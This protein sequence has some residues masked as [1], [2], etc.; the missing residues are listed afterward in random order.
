MMRARRRP[1]QRGWLA[2]ELP[3]RFCWPSAEWLPAI[4][5]TALFMLDYQ[6]SLTN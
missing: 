6:L 3:R 2:G 5:G 1:S 4:V